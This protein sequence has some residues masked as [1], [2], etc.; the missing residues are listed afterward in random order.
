MPS[1]TT[2]SGGLRRGSRDELLDAVVAQRLELGD[3]ALVHAAARV[4]I[5]RL[6]VDALDR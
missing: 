2:S 1:S 3:D 6:R 5:E 4:A